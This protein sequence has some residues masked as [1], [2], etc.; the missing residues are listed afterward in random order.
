MVKSTNFF[1]KILLV[2]SALIVTGCAVSSKTNKS[3]EPMQSTFTYNYEVKEKIKPDLWR[4]A[5]DY[6]ASAYGDSRSVFRVM[7]K[8]DGTII[9]QG[10]LAWSRQ[11]LLAHYNCSINYHIRFIAKDNKARLQFELIDNPSSESS[12]DGYSLPIAKG[13]EKIK[14][15]FSSIDN[16]LKLALQN[17]D[18]MSD[19]KSF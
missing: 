8:K 3:K 7:D 19:F 10:T 4:S 1:F 13:H 11:V 5:R 2:I 12:C 14:K 17:K 16:Q 15:E 18:A 9:G 6:F